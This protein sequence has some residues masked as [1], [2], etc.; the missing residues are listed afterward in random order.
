MTDPRAQRIAKFI[1]PLRVT[2]GSEVTLAKDFDPADTSQ[3]HKK[4]GKSILRQGVEVLADYQVR[5]AA[6]RH[7][8]RSRLPPGARRRRQGWDHSSRHERRQPPGRACQQ[9]QGSVR[10]GVGPRLSLAL[11]AAVAR[12]W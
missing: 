3:L 9:F 1:E 7:P 5:L 11:C 6:Q 4:A 8:R 2:P 12:P 10:S